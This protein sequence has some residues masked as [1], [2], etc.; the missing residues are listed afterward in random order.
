MTLNQWSKDLL[1]GLA[2][3]GIAG[4]VAGGFGC[5]AH[6][7]D[8]DDS[9]NAD[10][11][12]IA[13]VVDGDTV[14]TDEGETIR[15]IG[16]DTPERGDC[17][18][19]E[20]TARMV[21]LAEGREAML[22]DGAK[23][24]VDIYGRSLRYIEVENLDVGKTLIDEGLAIARYDSRDGYGSHDR[25]EM[26]VEADRESADGPCVTPT[27]TTTDPTT[28]TYYS[29]CSEARTAGAAPVHR[30]DPGYGSHLDR[31]GDGVA[32]E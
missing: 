1:A 2:G 18:F 21:E 25:E 23:D 12:I 6:A 16:I 22:I 9:A 26:Y 11:V 20:A 19:D 28:G 10:D 3:L 17:G 29:N 14:T 8:S 27:T 13:R 7:V 5:V 24:D 30:G 32:C 31:D 4:V 15:L